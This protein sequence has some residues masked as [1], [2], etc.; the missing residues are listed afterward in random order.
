MRTTDAVQGLFVD[1]WAVAASSPGMRKALRCWRHESDGLIDSATAGELLAFVKHRT[2]HARSRATSSWLLAVDEPHAQRIM[3]QAAHPFVL[4]EIGRSRLRGQDLADWSQSCAS[5]AVLAVGSLSG[6]AVPWPMWAIRREFR[7]ELMSLKVE[8]NLS[9][10]GPL[11]AWYPAADVV[12][13]AVELGQVL[14]SAV[15]AQRI[16]IRD[17]QMLWLS[18]TG[19]ATTAELAARVGIEPSS[20][21]KHQSR[22]VRRLAAPLAAA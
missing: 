10:A 13:H 16:S 12:D 2:D 14:R 17:A 18:A 7:N 11:E 9:G 20:L 5:A 6:R 15:T 1:E 4:G 21:R 19:L 3:V 8:Y 22:T